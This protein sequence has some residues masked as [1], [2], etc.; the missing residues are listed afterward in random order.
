MMRSNHPL[1]SCKF[2]EVLQLGEVTHL[3][4]FMKLMQRQCCQ[5]KDSHTHLIWNRLTQMGSSHGIFTLTGWLTTT[6]QI[7]LLIQSL[8]SVRESLTIHKL[9]LIISQDR[10]DIIQQI[11]ILLHVISNAKYKERSVLMRMYLPRQSPRTRK[12]A[13]TIKR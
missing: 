12:N 6:W 1:E 11:N 3:Y 2:V 8:S 13:K 5:L 10:E 9:L 4:V 7:Y